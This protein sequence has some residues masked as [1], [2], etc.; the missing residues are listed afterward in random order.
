[1]T[2]N[3]IEDS[4]DGFPPVI[5]REDDN[6]EGER[7]EDQLGLRGLAGRVA[8]VRRFDS[9]VAVASTPC[10]VATTDGVLRYFDT[11]GRED[12]EETHDLSLLLNDHAAS[13][14]LKICR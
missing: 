9:G 5:G 12:T 3:H 10:K 1:M 8:A 2:I 11:S 4:L 7:D 13:G 6:E 14:H